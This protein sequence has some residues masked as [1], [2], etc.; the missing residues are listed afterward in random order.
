[1]T[2][3]GSVTVPFSTVIEIYHVLHKEVY[4]H[5]VDVVGALMITEKGF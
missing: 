3:V 4:Q 1:V 5:I 2:Q